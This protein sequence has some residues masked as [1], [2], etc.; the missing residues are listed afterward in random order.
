[1]GSDRYTTIY[2]EMSL[3]V[4]ELVPQVESE[5]SGDKLYQ[6][7]ICSDSGKFPFEMILEC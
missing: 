1:M 7:E 4:S 2:L 6:N 5:Y 3:F